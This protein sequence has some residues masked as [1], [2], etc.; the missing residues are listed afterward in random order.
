MVNPGAEIPSAKAH[1]GSSLSLGSCHQQPK[2]TSGQSRSV[3][4]T[5]RLPRTLGSGLNLLGLIIRKPRPIQ[6][7]PV[8]P[9][10]CLFGHNHLGIWSPPQEKV[11][12]G[13]EYTG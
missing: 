12:A 8:D 9:T 10:F 7:T 11:L 1:M 4:G 2:T 6:I 5:P 3:L 13:G